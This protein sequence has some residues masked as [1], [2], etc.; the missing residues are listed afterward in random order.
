MP[1]TQDQIACFEDAITGYN[2]P[3]VY[4][5]FNAKKEIKAQN[6]TELETAIAEQLRSQEVNITKYG[7]ANVRYWGFAQ[8]GFRQKRINN[9]LKTFRNSKL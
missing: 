1:L 8:I 7:L 6:M 4:F 9:F 2:F 5:D 3:A